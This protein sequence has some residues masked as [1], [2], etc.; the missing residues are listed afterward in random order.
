MPN[1]IRRSCSAGV[2]TP[3]WNCHLSPAG[4]PA[5]GRLLFWEWPK[6]LR[7]RVRR[8]LLISQGL[9]PSNKLFGVRLKDARPQ[10]WTTGFFFLLIV[11]SWCTHSRSQQNISVRKHGF[12]TLLFIVH[13]CASMYVFTPQGTCDTPGVFAGVSSVCPPCRA[14]GLNSGR[15]I[16][17]K[18]L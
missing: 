10:T 2:D 1:S 5:Q 12:L 8:G 15:Q 18:A 14:Q 3:C 17:C 9:G 13:A 16:L 7:P 6:F 4:L 11:N